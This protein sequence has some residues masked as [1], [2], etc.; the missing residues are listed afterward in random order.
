[1]GKLSP[2]L[3][4]LGPVSRDFFPARASAQVMPQFLPIAFQL[5][6]IFS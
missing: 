4:D 5:L 2:V 1:L 6:A 3:A